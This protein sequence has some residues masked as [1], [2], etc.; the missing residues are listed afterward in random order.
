MSEDV[1][2]IL[3]TYSRYA[4][5]MADRRFDDWAD[6]FTEDARFINGAKVFEGRQELQA[7]ITR[8]WQD[9]RPA[10]NIW[11]NPLI[12]I[13]GDRAS[14]KVDYL[15]VGYPGPES[16]NLVVQSMGR[17]DDVLAKQ[18]DRWLIHERRVNAAG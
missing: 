3:S 15:V 14:A 17:Y 13:K 11:C 6:Q 18:G 5:A 8:R 16:P 10:K 7:F 4:Q 2:S 1:L 9:E 12:E